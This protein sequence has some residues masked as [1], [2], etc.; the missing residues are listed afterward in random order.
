MTIQEYEK[1]IDNLPSSQVRPFLMSIEFDDYVQLVH[2]YCF[3]DAM[4]RENAEEFEQY[5]K[6]PEQ[7]EYV[8][9]MFTE[10][11]HAPKQ[12]PSTTAYGLVMMF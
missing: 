2:E 6:E 11:P 3:R 4:V 9:D 10:R 1:K 12:F 8:K 7:Q 5:F